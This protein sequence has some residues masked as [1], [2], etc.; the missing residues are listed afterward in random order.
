M[1]PWLSLAI[2]A[3]ILLREQWVVRDGALDRLDHAFFTL[4]SLVG[5]VM[6]AG[7]LVHWV[8]LRGTV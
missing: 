7:Y 2:V 8:R 5:M 3:G 1:L 6:L 4:N